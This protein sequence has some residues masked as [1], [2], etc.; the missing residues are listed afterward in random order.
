LSFSKLS[1]AMHSLCLFWGVLLILYYFWQWFRC[2]FTT[3]T[4]LFHQHGF[5]SFLFFI[6]LTL[7]G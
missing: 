7:E 6:S 5:C 4:S 2:F 3:F 1:S